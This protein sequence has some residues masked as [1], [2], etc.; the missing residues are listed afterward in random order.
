MSYKKTNLTK[1]LSHQAAETT[2]TAKN[3]HELS[4]SEANFHED[5]YKVMADTSK[6]SQV[7][8]DF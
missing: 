7:R 5:F 2:F 8:K 6:S 1:T 4:L 3:V